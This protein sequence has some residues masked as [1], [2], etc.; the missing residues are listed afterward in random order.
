MSLLVA[1][2]VRPSRFSLSFLVLTLA[3]LL[4]PFTAQA[5]VNINGV[6][7]TLGSGFTG[8]SGVAVDAYGDVFV[9]DFFSNTVWEIVAVDG[10]IPALPV[11]NVLGSGFDNPNGVAVDAS[12]NVYVADTGHSSVKEILA[13][14]GIIPVSPTI[15]T[16]GSGF[17]FPTAVAVDASG[18]VYVADT[19]HNAIK[20]MLAVSGSVPLVSPTIN[21]LG[22]GFDHPEGVA[23]DSSGDVFAA[24][25]GHSAVKEMLAVSGSVPLVSPTIN[26]L[27]SG[28]DTPVGVAV[29][30]NGNVFVG[31]SNNGAVKEMLAVSGIVPGSPTI[32]SLGS[33]F[34]SPLGV[35]VDAHNNVF[36]ADLGNSAVYEIGIL[37]VNFGSQAIGSASAPIS[38]PFSISAG[39][40]VGSVV[41]LTLGAPSL[42]FAS[43]SGTTCAAQVYGSATNCIVN[44]TFTPAVAG[45]RSGAVV[46]YSGAGN[47]GT[48]LASVMIY[49]VGT[50]PQI[51]YGPG[52][53]TA[54]DPTVNS[55]G[56]AYTLGVAVDGAGDLY[57]ADPNHNRV[58]EVPAGVGSPTAINPTVNSAGL[59]SPYGVAVDGAGDLFIADYGNDRVVEVPTGGGTAI[60]IDPTVNSEGLSNPTSVALDGAGDLFIVDYSHNRVVV[61]PT[62]NG[63]ATA[64]DP[65]VNSKGLNAP[66]SAAV[67]GTGDLFIADEINNRV[68]EVPAGGGAATAIDPTV[69]SEQLSSPLGVAVDGAGD[70]FI[71]D[72]GH[73]RVVEVPAS[74]SA[75]AIDPTVNSDGLNGPTGVTVSG[76]GNLYISDPNNQRVVE[77]QHAQPPSVN[78]PTPTYVG[79]TDSTDGTMTVQVENIGNLALN[80]TG[81]SYPTDFPEVNGDENACTNSSSLSAGQECD[82]P[83]EFAPQS[84]GSPLSEDVTLTNNALNVIGAMQMIAV[85]GTALPNA[86]TPTFSPVGGTYT[87]IQTVTISDTTPG[88][89]IY[90][91]T[92][93]STPTTTSTVYTGPINVYGASSPT[94]LSA[95]AIASNYGPSAVGSATYT[96]ALIPTAITSPTPSSQ[97]TGTS[98]TFTWTPGNDGA[99]HFELWVGTTGVGTSNLYNS[100]SVTATSETV[101]GLPSNA[102][103]VY[104]RLYYFAYGAWESTDYTYTAYGGTTP[105]ALT[106]PSPGSTLTGTSVTFSW[107]PGNSATHF[108]LYLGTTGVGSNNLYNSGS[109][110]VTSETVSDLPSNGQPVYARL[111]WYISGTWYSADYTYTATGSATPAALTTPSPGSTLTGTS[112]T[113]SWSPGNTAT[114][115][116]LYLGTT[117]VGSSNLYNSGSVTVTSETV[118]DLP[119]N[120]QPVYARLYWLINGV[121]SSADYTYKATG[122]TTPAVLTTPT[123]GSTLTGTSAAF[124]WSTGNAATHF[125]LFLGSTGVGS[126]NLY[127]S[128]SVTVTSETVS[129]LPSNGQPVYA[130]LYWYISGT[131]YS[132]DYTYTATGSPTPAAL[133][134]PSPGSTLTGT[135]AAFSWIP[136]N[137]AVHFMLYLGSTGVGSSNLYNSG[138][139]TVTTE[140]VNGLP[141]NSEKIYARLYWYI[142]GV[143]NFADYTYT[144]H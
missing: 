122:T 100:N 17:D 129:D 141:S 79:A 80:F 101:G 3:C 86:A 64:I 42:D 28:F 139:V 133:T 118:S 72:D 44:V 9:A 29:D 143:W 140:T 41:V 31:D 40:T 50:G 43:V 130:R 11:I 93:G 81:V 30:W 21:T 26:T 18:N 99:V 16:L 25:T 114:H 98:V 144:A 137:T 68:V 63:P 15:N 27:G 120:G 14:D 113:F 77:I 91:T 136:G 117:G 121:W 134:T 59:S 106:T 52:T 76:T 53:A 2:R 88:A 49:G 60:A 22:S 112:V 13:V 127:N 116:Q 124:S 10:S 119:S 5:Q 6:Q 1:F 56:L 39:T 90:Y 104:V 85:G 128:G 7:T 70:L 92:N 97:L 35:A 48:V 105:A 36:I 66:F 87:P 61:M 89:T 45:L 138:S 110:T 107:A 71:V 20:E 4:L 54:I 78:F 69:N 115:F 131:W 51:A 37:S 46:F 108:Q 126:S 32:L 75:F 102:E 111:Y 109:V 23:V 135:T 34:D 142:D 84:P 125:Q 95:I 55:E 12:G 38:L 8:P 65:T 58:I 132:A 73:D 33:D 74:G 19:Y 123:P 47:T 96:I 82:L 57:I 83:I 103:T 24:D 94:T 62:G 67:D